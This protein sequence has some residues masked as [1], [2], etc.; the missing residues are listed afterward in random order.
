ART[1]TIL[2]NKNHGT[3]PPQAFT[4]LYTTGEQGSHV[5]QKLAFL[6]YRK[7]HPFCLHHHRTYPLCTTCFLS[8]PEEFLAYF[9]DQ[10]SGVLVF[11]VLRAHQKLNY[12]VVELATEMLQP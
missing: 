4:A 6:S 5:S 10:N 2:E 8:D 12:L 11:Q 7:P 9:L 3:M 1:I